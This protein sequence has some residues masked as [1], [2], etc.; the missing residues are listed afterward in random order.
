M[1][2]IEKLDAEIAGLQA[3]AARVEAMPPTVAERYAR[4]EV[5]LLDA[6]RVYRDRGLNPSAAHPG[7]MAHLQRLAVV[8]VAAAL[9]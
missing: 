7:E 2:A 9:A 3:E 1:T 5:E 6:E 4:V 8:T